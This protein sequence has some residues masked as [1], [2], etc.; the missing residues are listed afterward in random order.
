MLLL[1]CDD[2]RRI[3]STSPNTEHQLWNCSSYQ[4]MPTC[5]VTSSTVVSISPHHT[6]GMPKTILASESCVN[7]LIVYEF[8]V[9]QYLF[10]C[11]REAM[12]CESMLRDLCSGQPR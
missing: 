4:S 3:T 8:K 2:S 5:V 6:I 1:E 9:A 10:E 7:P 11:L 12:K